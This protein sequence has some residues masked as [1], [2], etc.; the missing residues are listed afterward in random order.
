MRYTAIA[1]IFLFSTSIPAAEFIPK[2]LSQMVDDLGVGSH[3]ADT[4][5]PH[6]TSTTQ[7][8]LTVGSMTVTTS[9]NLG[10][11][12]LSGYVK[13]NGGSATS[14]QLTSV[15]IISGTATLSDVKLSG[16]TAIGTT[17]AATDVVDIDLGSGNMLIQ[18]SSG[19]PKTQEIRGGSAAD[20]NILATKIY[21]GKD[22]AGN[23]TNY[24]GIYAVSNNV[25]NGSETGSIDFYLSDGGSYAFRGCWK[26][27]KLGIGTSTPQT[28]LAVAG[29]ISLQSSGYL[30]FGNGTSSNGYGVRDNS[31]TMQYKNTA[32]AWSDIPSG[33][34]SGGWTDN[35]TTIVETTVI[36]QVVIGSTTTA[37]N[38]ILT[39]VGSQ[40]TTD[41][42]VTNAMSI[43]FTGTPMVDLAIGDNDT[44]INQSSD[45]II[46][47]VA[48]GASTL[49]LDGTTGRVRIATSTSNTTLQVGGTVTAGGFSGNGAGLTGIT[50][51]FTAVTGSAT[52]AQLPLISGLLGSATA[53]QLPINATFVGTQNTFG[54]T[55]PWNSSVVTIYG[56]GTNMFSVV[57]EYGGVG[58]NTTFVM[59]GTNTPSPNIVLVD[60]TYGDGGGIYNGYYAFDNIVGTNYDRWVMSGATPTWISYDYGTGTSHI[61]NHY[62]IA[63]DNNVS[64]PT[65]WTFEG[66]NDN[67]TFTPIDQQ[68]GQTFTNFIYNSYMIATSTTSYQIY[69]LNISA[70]ADTVLSIS[71]IQLID[72]EVDTLLCVSNNKVL[73]G[74]TTSN[75]TS[76]STPGYVLQV[77]GSGLAAS[78]G[79]TCYE[80][81][82]SIVGSGSDVIEE[83]YNAVMNTKLFKHHPKIRNDITLGQAE[84]IA[85][86]EY[87]KSFEATDYETFKAKGTDTAAN[88]KRLR[89]DEFDTLS[90]KAKRV[91]QR[92]VE[93]ESDTSITSITPVSDDPSTPDIFKRGDNR[94]LDLE[95]QIGC[96]IGTAQHQDAEIKE[97][98]LLLNK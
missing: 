31:G 58:T 98:K 62:K 18:S 26:G 89:K 27:A 60:R 80:A 40:T 71:E 48:A 5:N 47:L 95:N 90:D 45:N 61:L 79:V 9:L 28:Q 73:I 86:T 21:Q 65:A 63:T 6:G 34:S 4:S 23:S 1:L 15:Q 13:D 32:G 77:D 7:T 76:T 87:V 84:E 59:T 82:K 91:R 25:T 74:T 39:V 19:Y 16:N 51:A 30:N 52:S 92:K 42:N 38:Q 10:T 36:D 11:I 46:A 72:R 29:D 81:I 20:G 22:S 78:W 37:S 69:R 24:A 83:G 33:T 75:S 96:L 54:T 44:G 64:R 17:T 14:T 50:F 41:L 55:T 12:T 67:I 56:S 2:K 8:N 53:S 35:G 43:A 85:K 88:W 66:S 68:T 94:I 97:L 57:S 49:V 70:K 3:T 93:L